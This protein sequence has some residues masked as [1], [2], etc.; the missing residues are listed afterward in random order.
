MTLLRVGH[1]DVEAAFFAGLAR[2][3]KKVQYYHFY[4]YTNMIP[5]LPASAVPRL[6][7]ELAAF[8]RRAEHVGE[9]WQKAI[10]KLK[11]KSEAT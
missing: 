4:W 5:R 8:P 6:E 3:P 9:D 1:P 7:A 10:D 2:R 11:G